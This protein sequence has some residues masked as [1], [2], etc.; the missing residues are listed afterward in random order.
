MRHDSDGFARWDAAQ[1]LATRVLQRRMDGDG[2]GD[3]VAD[4]G[5]LAAFRALL[6]GPDADPAM[7][8]QVLT[9]PAESYLAELAGS[10]DPPRIHAARRAE[11]VA[12]A[13]ALRAELLAC[14]ERCS[15]RESYAPSA[16][17][18]A[19]RSLKNVCLGYLVL[20]ADGSGLVLA[21]QQYHA[22]DNMS[23]RLAALG[24]VVHHDGTP[25]RER[26]ARLLEDFRSRWS[27]EALVM[28]LWLQV[29]A[30]RP[31]A[32]ALEDVQRLQRHAAYDARNPN[33][34]RALL[35][36]FSAGNAPGFHRIDHA[37]YRF[38][39][40]QVA[41]IDA[42]NPQLAARL[43]APLTRWRRHATPFAEGM[44]EA[45]STLQGKALS[46]DCFEVVSKSLA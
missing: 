23:D 18:I 37:G 12:L 42:Q 1:T 39:A 16:A 3:V 24:A 46:P 26:A 15:Q 28:N 19:R 14:H 4:P 13:A 40:E 10:I 9:L 32:D 22:A 34:V 30:Q 25:R 33:K 36:A 17:Q 20:L 43:L 11:R 29:Q 38:L 44:H 8:A 27:H 5:L 45:L 35:G 31:A 41:T 6:A 21:E 2:S 7:V